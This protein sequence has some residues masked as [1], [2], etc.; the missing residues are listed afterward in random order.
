MSL[1]KIMSLVDANAD[2]LPDGAYLELCNELKAV[3]K[4]QPPSVRVAEEAKQKKMERLY[5]S[6][7]EFKEYL[8]H[9]EEAMEAD[10]RYKEWLSDLENLEGEVPEK[11]HAMCVNAYIREGDSKVARVFLRR[12]RLQRVDV[13]GLRL[14]GV[15]IPDA[16]AFYAHWFPKLKNQFIEHVE[17]SMSGGGADYAWCEF[18]QT[19]GFEDALSLIQRGQRAIEW[20][21]RFECGAFEETDGGVSGA[22]VEFPMTFVKPVVEEQP[23]LS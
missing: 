6:V 10:Q 9:V 21:R 3:W 12:L 22:C 23:D 7:Y 4:R 1:S 18:S 11:Y 15:D 19:P 17:M 5:E 13:E 2:K 8:R 16:E 20:R 14:A